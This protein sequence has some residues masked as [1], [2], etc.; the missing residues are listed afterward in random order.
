M[1]ILGLLKEVDV[2]EKRYAT[3]FIL[4]S[5]LFSVSQKID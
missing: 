1:I 2:F 3:S 5:W 4:L